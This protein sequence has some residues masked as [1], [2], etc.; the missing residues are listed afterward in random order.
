MLESGTEHSDTA[1]PLAQSCCSCLLR[2]APGAA[3][4]PLLACLKEAR[5]RNPCR[6]KTLRT[7]K[8]QAPQ[9]GAA[10]V[11][12]TPCGGSRAQQT[13]PG[14][15][16]RAENGARGLCRGVSVI[17]AS[18]NCSDA[19]SD[20]AAVEERWLSFPFSFIPSFSS[21]SSLGEPV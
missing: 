5:G 17:A 4:G 13:S 6:G 3:P 11:P 14:G 20:R 7:E 21:A 16:L 15:R 18:L 8:A 19:S 9:R 12:V 1:S 10:D 2:A